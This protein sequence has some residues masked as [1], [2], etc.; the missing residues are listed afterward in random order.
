M[1]AVDNKDASR[2]G[3]TTDLSGSRPRR[4]MNGWS[5]QQEQLMAKW[6]DVATCYRWLHDRADKKYSRLSMSINIPVI[7]LS[8]LTGAANFAVGSFIPPEDVTMKNYVSAG[9]GG[10]S[11]V[12][13]IITTLGNFFQYAQK[14]EANRVAGIAWG[15]F[16]RLVSV[17]LAIS[18]DDRLDAMDFLKICR[19][20]LDRLIEQS[21]PISEDIIKMFEKEFHSVPNLKVP[22]ICHGI[23]HTHVYNS[24]DM[25]LGKIA[26]DAAMHIRYKKNMLAQSVLPDIDKKIEHELST[27][28]EKRIKELISS[29]NTAKTESA[30]DVSSIVTNLETDWRQLLVMRKKILVPPPY[31]VHTEEPPPPPLPETKPDEIRLNI[32]GTDRPG[33]HTQTPVNTS[34][35]D[36]L[37]TTTSATTPSARRRPPPPPLF[38]FP[39]PPSHSAKVS[40][41]SSRSS[42]N[43]EQEDAERKTAEIPLEETVNP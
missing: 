42:V 12:A 40:V 20:D 10:L 9:L 30:V 19:Q 25:R 6:A 5:K 1:S 18:P 4:F 33:S 28:I 38:V 8:T 34:G 32:V 16:Q 27:R 13:G 2:R 35:D 36:N 3:S 23:E 31:N 43:I 41:S 26:A 39:V 37:S 14:S 11:I 21:P 17:E 24:N 22:D 7:I 29:S 15:K